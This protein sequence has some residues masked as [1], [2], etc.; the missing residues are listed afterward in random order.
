[1]KAELNRRYAQ[2]VDGRCH[3]IFTSKDLPEWQDAAFGVVDITDF[4]QEPTVG[5]TLAN[6]VFTSPPA[7]PPEKDLVDQIVAL[8]A[9]RKKVL[10]AAL[11]LAAKE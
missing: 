4:R 10:Q 9:D 1:M 5:D 6:G 2:I 8:S 3:W 11:A 7:P